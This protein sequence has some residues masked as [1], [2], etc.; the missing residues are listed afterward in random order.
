VLAVKQPEPPPR[1]FDII[2]LAHE[3][4]DDTDQGE[5]AALRNLPG[6]A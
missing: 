6:A 3:P 5:R 2:E 1:C 4:A